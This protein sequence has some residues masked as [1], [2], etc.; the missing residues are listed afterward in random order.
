VPMG[1]T[2][3]AARTAP[4]IHWWPTLLGVAA[5]TGQAFGAR[6]G[7]AAIVM[8]CAVIYL[9]AAVTAR[10]WAAWIGFAASLPLVGLAVVLRTE[11]PSLVAIGVAGIVLVVVGFVRG[12]WRDRVNRYQ[13]IAAPVFGAL[14]VVA[15]LV[16][17]VAVPLIVVGLVAHA[18]WDVVHHRRRWVVA[19]QY[20]E[21]CAALDLVLAVLVVVLAVVWG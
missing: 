13:L 7:F 18:A 21:F 4:G 9:L 10:P 16:P 17:V 12:T 8:V 5:A 1:E 6:T 19:P 3:T 20:A 2:T 11:W 14:A 15:A